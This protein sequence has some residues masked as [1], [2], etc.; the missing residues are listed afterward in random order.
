MPKKSEILCEIHNSKAQVQNKTTNH[1]PI[2]KRG[3]EDHVI[4]TQTIK[5]VVQI[6]KTR[7]AEREVQE[8]LTYN[9]PCM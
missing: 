3:H 6:Q 2:N 5:E 1:Q 4:S 8:T 9:D 7:L